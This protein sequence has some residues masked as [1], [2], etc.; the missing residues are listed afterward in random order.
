MKNFLIIMLAMLPVVTASAQTKD[1]PNIKRKGLITATM[2]YIQAYILKS[3][4]TSFRRS[5]AMTHGLKYTAMSMVRRTA[6]TSM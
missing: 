2:D 3:D 4:I 1:R 6:S 5:I